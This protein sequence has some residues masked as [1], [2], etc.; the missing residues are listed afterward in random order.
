MGS[1]EWLVAVRAGAPVCTGEYHSP[2]PTVFYRASSSSLDSESAGSAPSIS[3]RRFP[4]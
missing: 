1:G 2:L 3:T 4:T